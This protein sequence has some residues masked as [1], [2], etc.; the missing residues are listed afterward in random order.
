MT[1]HVADIVLSSAKAACAHV[2]KPIMSRTIRIFLTERLPHAQFHLDMAR[3]RAEQ[4]LREGR[5]KPV[6]VLAANLFLSAEFDPSVSAPYAVFEGLQLG[7]VRDLTGDI[8]GMQ[9]RA[10][11][12]VRLCSTL[13]ERASWCC[14]RMAAEQPVLGNAR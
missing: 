14:V 2:A 12:C 8:R 3:Q 9:A 6:D 11:P 13:C 4:R 5:A 7:D 1:A 10:C